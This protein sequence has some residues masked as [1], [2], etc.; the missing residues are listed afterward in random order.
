MVSMSLP[1]IA[2]NAGMEGV[3]HPHMHGAIIELTVKLG[4]SPLDRK[5]VR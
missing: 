4:D 3:A 2:A 5:R 1:A